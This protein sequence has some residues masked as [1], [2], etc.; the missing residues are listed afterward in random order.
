MKKL[1]LFF[2]VF[3]T[4]FAQTYFY[5]DDKGKIGTIIH[6]KK[7]SKTLDIKTYKFDS[8]IIPVKINRESEIIY[9]INFE[10]SVESSTFDGKYYWRTELESEYEFEMFRTYE[11]GQIRS[12]GK[13]LKTKGIGSNLYYPGYKEKI[14]KGTCKRHAVCEDIIVRNG[15][16]NVW[17]PNGNLK[18]TFFLKNVFQ[19]GIG[20]SY[21]ETGS[22]SYKG[23]FINGRYDGIHYD[24]YPS[25]YV[26]AKS[27]FSYDEVEDIVSRDKIDYSETDQQIVIGKNLER[28][29]QVAKEKHIAT[30]GDNATEVKLDSQKKLVTI[31]TSEGY[32][33]GNYTSF[34]FKGTYITSKSGYEEYVDW[35]QINYEA[36]KIRRAFGYEPT[37]GWYRERVEDYT[38]SHYVTKDVENTVEYQI[39]CSNGECEL[40]R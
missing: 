11:N 18:H 16:W 22:L 28:A 12:R 13:A 14:S 25:G 7:A 10:S 37:D 32:Y 40:L 3:N 24:F 33:Q 1:L 19:D 29:L 23:N 5:K 21:H 9:T 2:C 34:V 36:D 27:K 15:Q 8:K 20:K 35:G 17:W 26:K 31:K 38:Y 4:L 39:E 30:F 6:D